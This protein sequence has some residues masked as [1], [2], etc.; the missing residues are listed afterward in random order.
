MVGATRH[1]G[2]YHRRPMRR[3][4]SLVIV[5]V[6]AVAAGATAGG[7]ASGPRAQSVSLAISFPEG[8]SVR[9]MSDRVAEVRRIAIRRRNVTP[10]L[11][12]AAYWEAASRTRPPAAFRPQMKNP[13]KIEG[14]LFPSLYRFG[15]TT[16][17][18]ELITLQLS[19]F[20]REWRKVDLRRARARGVT[21]YG[22]LTIASIVEREVV[23]PEERA[24]VAAVIYNRLRRNMPLGIDATLRYGLG[25]EGTR[26]LTRAHLASDSP[27]N[28]SRFRGLPPTPIG[29]PGLP[30][31]RAAARPANVDYLFYVVKPGTCGEHAFSSTDAEFQR[32]VARYNAERAKRGGRSPTDC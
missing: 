30:S 14:F 4:L 21:P 29:N 32:D 31:M 16:R 18:E 3:R 19:A 1:G 25:I 5:C 9:Q 7:A 11:T 15:P 8:F 6:A 26:P 20:S 28:T 13:R 24:L 22:V 27:Y 17:A 12:G 2:R 10:R 23:V